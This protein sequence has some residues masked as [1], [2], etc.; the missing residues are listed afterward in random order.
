M[1]VYLQNAH[2]LT[3]LGV[4]K[5]VQLLKDDEDLTGAQKKKIAEKVVKN[6]RP[7]Q[8]VNAHPS[9]IPE[10]IRLRGTRPGQHWET[11]LTE[12]K[13]AKYGL[14]YLL[15]FVDTF[16]GWVE[17]FQPSMKQLLWW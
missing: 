17:A 10:G 3:H 4:K 6:C 12:I 2:K 1:E 15:V 11:D 9:K 7:C 13:P 14:R 16:S 8:M 5:L